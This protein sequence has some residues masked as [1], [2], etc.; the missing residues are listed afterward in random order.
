MITKI[1]IK[2]FLSY[3]TTEI[4]VPK[5]LGLIIGDNGI[6]GSN[7]S[8]KSGL[9]EAITWGLWG[10][11][12][13][14]ETFPS[15]DALIRRGTSRTEVGIQVVDRD[16]VTLKST[17]SRISTGKGTTVLD[18]TYSEPYFFGKSIADT[19]KD[20]I[21]L[22]G[23][24]FDLFKHTYFIKPGESS[25]FSL[26]PPREAKLMIMNI[27][28][29]SKWEKY[30]NAAKDKHHTSERLVNDIGVIINTLQSQLDG[31]DKDRLNE[32][33]GD[34]KSKTE[35]L[36]IDITTFKTKISTCTK[37]DEKLSKDLA[38]AEA[39]Y[40]T[41]A[42]KQIE[43]AKRH[44]STE[45]AINN[46]SNNV[47]SM[48]TSISNKNIEIDRCQNEIEDASK[49][50]FEYTRE[51]ADMSEEEFVT[52]IDAQK[53][54]I[55]D[56]KNNLIEI[57][58]KIGINKSKIDTNE[59]RIDELSSN[60]DSG[61][62]P[63]LGE[64]CDRVTQD[65][66]SPTI[67]ELKEEINNIMEEN[68]KLFEEEKDQVEAR[69]RLDAES[70][71]L[72]KKLTWFRAKQN[73]AISLSSKCEQ[74]KES[75][76]NYNDL[77]GELEENLKSAHEMLVNEKNN[78]TEIDNELN[79]L[80]TSHMKES[81]DKINNIKSQRSF[82][83]G[84]IKELEKESTERTDELNIT[85]GNI[86][87][88][89]S[90]LTEIE[91]TEDEVLLKKQD[92]EKHRLDTTILKQVMD[93]FSKDGIPLHMI[94][95]SAATIEN[96]ANGILAEIGKN[97]SIKIKVEKENK[98][99]GKIKDTFEI[100]IMQDGHEVLYRMYSGGESFW[101]DFALRMSLAIVEHNISGSMMDT[102]II[103]EGIGRLDSF[104]RE[105]FVNVLRFVISNH[106]VSQILLVTHTDISESQRTIFDFI[107]TAT[108]DNGV[109]SLECITV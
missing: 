11:A 109:S 95:I 48:E 46:I 61:I 23:M 63:V 1:N 17:R 58:T 99:D 53:Q 35:E 90:Q 86:A 37:E 73:A 38:E 34:Y 3:G 15:G 105:L 18:V 106:H 56:I 79:Q 64:K 76:S 32:Q 84:D 69:A 2:D 108:K 24:D 94:D 42:D 29:L 87:V 82:I 67:H 80:D 77:I 102:F 19:Q 107:I 92:L 49:K 100:V 65:A 31:K 54:P 27:L 43:L 88:A 97:I 41:D 10:N 96:I 44:K 81:L 21:R 16:G 75:I 40:N 22:L 93:V 13:S 7:G 71:E 26:L 72:Q 83:S 12:R 91:D 28:N 85:L 66:I 70:D 25:N 68:K 60:D 36:N 30:H 104:N 45:D 62:C 47:H 33:I 52:K 20:L 101:I 51:I 98:K 14:T 55:E 39:S 9:I 59:S 8:G 103:D 74:Y 89:E 6:G 50:I 78:F 5:G 4:E 57:I